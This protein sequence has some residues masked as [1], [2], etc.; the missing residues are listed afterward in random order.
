MALTPL[1]T[2][3][4]DTCSTSYAETGTIETS[5]LYVEIL[6]PIDASTLAVQ[7]T[8]S[9]TATLLFEG[10]V[11]GDDYISME[12]QPLPSGSIVT[13][14]TGNGAW[15]TNVAGYS[16]FRVR[17]TAITLEADVS[18]R[19]TSGPATLPVSTDNTLALTWAR[20][21]VTLTG[22]TDQVLLAADASRRAIMLYNR[23][24]NDLARY[25]IAGQSI[26]AAAD[27]GIP[28]NA[29]ISLHSYSGQDAPTGTITITGTAGNI[30]TVYAGTTA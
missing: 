18:I 13:S 2:D 20:S 10:T 21:A 23:D 7:I 5:N 19:V 15:Q 30:I 6:L 26:N 27:E 11:N 16:K 25:D 17:T 28:L 14:A 22:A 29:G 24:T 8:G 4:C 9:W 3:G 12:M 1:F